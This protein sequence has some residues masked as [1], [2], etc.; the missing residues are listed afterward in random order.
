MRGFFIILIGLL[1]AF[2]ACSVSNLPRK[3]WHVMQRE[4]QPTDSVIF[5]V[6]SYQKIRSVGLGDTLAQVEAKVGFR[7][8]KYYIHPG[9]ALLETVT[10]GK[11][12]EVAFKY[13][14]LDIVQDISYRKIDQ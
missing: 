4:Y 11:T 3:S 10:D 13:D 12:Y 6:V 14:E 7:P 8:V 9:F 5:P 2:T 1:F